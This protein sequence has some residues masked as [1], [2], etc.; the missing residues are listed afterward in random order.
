M[1]TYAYAA[2]SPQS[3]NYVLSL[4]GRNSRMR[5]RVFIHNEEIGDTPNHTDNTEDVEN[6]RPAA[7]ETVFAKQAT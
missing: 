2:S 3:M 5:A 1:I 4:I 7:G 6:G